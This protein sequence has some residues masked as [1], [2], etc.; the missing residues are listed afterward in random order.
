MTIKIITDSGA[1][2]TTPTIN[3]IDHVTVPLTLTVSGNHYVDDTNLDL[4][5]FQAALFSSKEK[6]GSACPST[7]AWTQ[8]FVGADEIYVITIA[9]AL[10]GSF[11]AARHAAEIYQEEHP[12]VKIHVFNSKVAGPAMAL[13][14][15]Q[16][17]QLVNQGRTFE[18]V[19]TQTEATLAN[20]KLLF[21]LQSLN[22]LANNG[23]V[24]PA[25]AKLAQALG[26][27]VI[28]STSA[29]GNFELVAKTRKGKRVLNKLVDQ[30]TDRGFR[31]GRVI[32]DHVANLAGANQLAT[33]ITATYP[34]VQIT[35][36]QCRGLCSLYAEEGG[37]MI[38]FAAG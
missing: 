19:V 4:P 29:D 8:A 15:E 26:I 16:I 23:R 10:S 9:A 30:L 7:G 20:N 3:G 22:N 27:N 21:M 38:G 2:L 25:L 33:L 18:E 35:I 1:N 14:A 11:N 32:I 12:E 31:G 6:T 34:T 5:S 36:N 37:L 13:L 28:G 17:A 24:N